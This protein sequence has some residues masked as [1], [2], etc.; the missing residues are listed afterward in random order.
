MYKE[1]LSGISHLRMVQ[2]AIESCSF[3]LHVGKMGNAA[4]L[5]IAWHIA[6]QVAQKPLALYTPK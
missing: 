6:E 1:Y 5:R 4:T 3:R 2:V